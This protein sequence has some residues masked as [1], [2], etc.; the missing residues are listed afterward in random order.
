RMINFFKD[1]ATTETQG[2]VLVVSHG[3]PIQILRAIHRDDSPADHRMGSSV[4]PADYIRLCD[5]SPA[6]HDRVVAMMTT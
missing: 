6:F 4:E 3:D 1:L 5:Q 2:D